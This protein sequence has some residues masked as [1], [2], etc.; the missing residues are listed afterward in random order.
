[1]HTF[2]YEQRI[3][4]RVEYVNGA[5]ELHSIKRLWEQQREILYCLGE[6]ELD[7]SCCG[8]V[9]LS[10]ALVIGEMV[11]RDVRKTSDG[12]S[13]SVVRAISDTESQRRIRAQLLASENISEVNFYVPIFESDDRTG[14]RKS[15]G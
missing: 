13:V 4:Q 15:T 1:M 11:E 7:N 9:G 14:N 8:L 10:Y 5:Y 2:D 6:A 12:H 3:P